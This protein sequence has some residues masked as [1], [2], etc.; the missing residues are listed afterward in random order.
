DPCLTYWSRMEEHFF[1]LLESL[2]NDWDAAT[3]DSKPD[4]EQTARLTWRQS[5]KL[6]A[7]RALLESIELFGT[8]ARAIQAI[9][10]V[11]TD[12]YDIDLDQKSVKKKK[13]K[14]K[15]EHNNES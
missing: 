6:E 1:A 10:H 3:G 15:E 13:V 4:E 8:T 12:F 9:A 7:K 2:P 14:G 5:V 11:S